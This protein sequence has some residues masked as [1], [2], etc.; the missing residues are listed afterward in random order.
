[1]LDKILDKYIEILEKYF[2]CNDGREVEAAQ[3]IHAL[4]YEIAEEVLEEWRKSL[5]GAGARMCA[6]YSNYP[7]WLNSKKE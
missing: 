3:E 6:D 7:H 4:R 1:M 2:V 5:P